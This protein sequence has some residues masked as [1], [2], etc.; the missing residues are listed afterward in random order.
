MKSESVVCPVSAKVSADDGS[1][2]S[3]N[4]NAGGT[5][6]SVGDKFTVAGGSNGTG[7]IVRASRVGSLQATAVDVAGADTQQVQGSPRRIR[8]NH[9][10]RTDGWNSNDGNWTGLDHRSKLFQGATT[11]GFIRRL[12]RIQSTQSRNSS[13]SP[14]STST[15]I[16]PLGF[17]SAEKLVQ[18]I[19]LPCSRDHREI[20]LFGVTNIEVWYN[21]G[22]ANFPFSFI[23]GSVYLAW[24]RGALLQRNALGR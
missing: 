22:N 17:A 11:C 14:T 8:T 9:W 4:V 23:Q 1:L 16:N 15:N 6:W 18:I 24:H 5:G 13:G 2:A 19:S 21:S 20:W 3:V 7:V 10:N 12:Y